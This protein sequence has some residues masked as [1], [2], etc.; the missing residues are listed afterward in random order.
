MFFSVLGKVAMSSGDQSIEVQGGFQRA[1][2]IVL[3]MSSRRMV[4]ADTLID[5]LWSEHAPRHAENALQAHVSRLR[6]KLEELEPDR[7]VPRLARLPRVAS[8]PSGY[9]LLLED[10]ELDGA[11][12]MRTLQEIRQRPAPDP[13]EAVRKIRAALSLWSGPPFGGFRGGPICQAAATLYDE[14]RLAAMGLLFDNELRLGRHFEIIP[15]L[16]EQVESGS[17]NERL[18]EQLMVA[19]YRA[20][21]QTDALAAYRRMRARLNDELGI[22]PSP[23]L[24]RCER[25]I[26]SHD[27]ALERSEPTAELVDSR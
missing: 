14:S 24:Q 8:R 7:R 22:E 17:L 10:D 26:L 19:L 11:L 13:S 21:R 18:C 25:A 2:V 6:R 20:G 15:E 9:R 3:L 5:E 12:F 16:S 4:P 27:P 1:V 23:S